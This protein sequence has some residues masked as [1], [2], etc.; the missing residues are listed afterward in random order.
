MLLDLPADWEVF[1]KQVGSRLRQV[2]KARQAGLVVRQGVEPDLLADFFRVFS[3]RM[4]EFF[5]PVYPLAFFQK[6]L[7]VFPERCR[8]AGGL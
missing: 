1:E 6:I 8:A 3:L 2:R 4:R 5:F 7:Q